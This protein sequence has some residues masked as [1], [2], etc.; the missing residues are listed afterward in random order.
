MQYGRAPALPLGSPPPTELPKLFIESNDEKNGAF[1]WDTA[2]QKVIDEV[3][4]FAYIKI[5]IYVVNRLETPDGFSGITHESL[6]DCFMNSVNWETLPTHEVG[7]MLN[8]ST[9][10]K[11]QG[12]AHDEGPW[13]KELSTNSTGLL[14]ESVTYSTQW[15]RHED[16]YEAN[17][18]AKAK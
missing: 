17:L 1:P 10:G 12:N 9:E 8:L 7:H 6:K 4:A 11:G 15:L 18:K 13:P 5:P 16:W 3:G 14:T 2:R